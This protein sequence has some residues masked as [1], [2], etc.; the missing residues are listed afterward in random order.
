MKQFDIEILETN[1][2]V[3]QVSAKDKEEAM[4]IVTEMYVN[5]EITLN[6]NDFIDYKISFV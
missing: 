3:I 4:N 1:A 2:K 6:A 5:G